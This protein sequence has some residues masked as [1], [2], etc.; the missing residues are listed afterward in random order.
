MIFSHKKFSDPIHV[1]NSIVDDLGNKIPIGD[2]KDLGEFNL[3][4]LERIQEGLQLADEH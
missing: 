3:N 1:L 4:F 2:E